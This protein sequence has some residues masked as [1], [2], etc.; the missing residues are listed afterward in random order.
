MYMGLKDLGSN[1][2]QFLSLEL[3]EFSEKHFYF[4]S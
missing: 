4:V 1:Q 2:E 3:D